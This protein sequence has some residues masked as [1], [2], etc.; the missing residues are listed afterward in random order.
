M[1]KYLPYIAI[2][3]LLVSL[4]VSLTNRKE[5]EIV[6]TT[7]DTVYSLRIDTVFVEKPPFVSEVIVDTI[8]VQN[9]EKDTILL[10]IS[11]RYYSDA[12]YEAW[13]SGYRP[14]LDS[15]RVFGKTEYRTVTNTVAKE[16]YPKTTDIYLTGGLMSIGN[17]IS[18]NIGI[19]L[20]TKRDI[21]V[22]GT[23]GYY[24]RS[25]YYGIN[26]GFKLK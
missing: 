24:D 3:V 2:A 1:R 13:V 21:V 7:S 14:N 16:I 6:R 20:K 15:I 10:P 9:E 8:F 25:V 4:F 22:G 18:P 17:S 11:Q 5:V 26:V 19:S 12:Q 23:V